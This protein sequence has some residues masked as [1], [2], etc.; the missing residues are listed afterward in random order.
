MAT[1]QVY[2]HGR[3]LVAWIKATSHQEAAKLF[4]RATRL[5]SFAQL[6]G[7]RQPPKNSFLG[8]LRSLSSQC[9]GPRIAYSSDG[10][11]KPG[12]TFES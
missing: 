9:R 3:V 4:L 8:T 7:S 6:A 2:V 5:L 11:Q 10:G 12:F 1:Y